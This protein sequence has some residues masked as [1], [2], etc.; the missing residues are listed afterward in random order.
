MKL[1]FEITSSCSRKPGGGGGYFRN[2]WGGGG[3]G[4]GGLGNRANNE[5]SAK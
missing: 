3:V 1:S 4:K 5:A 2:F